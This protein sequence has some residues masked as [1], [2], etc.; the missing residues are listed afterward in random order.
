MQVEADHGQTSQALKIYETLR[1]KLHRE[2]GV[3]PEPATT[4]LY[5]TI[6][7]RRA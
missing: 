5:D 6:R 3:K 2:L 7:L 1:N 4:Q